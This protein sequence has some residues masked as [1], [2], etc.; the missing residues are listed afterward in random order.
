MIPFSFVHIKILLTHLSSD[1][2]ILYFSVVI[3]IL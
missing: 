3:Q 2:V 1:D